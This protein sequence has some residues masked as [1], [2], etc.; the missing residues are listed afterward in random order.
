[1]NRLCI[2]CKKQITGYASWVKRAKFCS[3][4]CRYGWMK[5]NFN[6]SKKSIKRMSD[7]KKWFYTTHSA[8]NKNKKMPKSFGEKLRKL[9]SGRIVSD[10]TKKRMKRNHA[11]YRMNKHP[12][13][14]GGFYFRDGYVYVISKEHPFANG[15]GYVKKSRL[16]MEKHLTRFLKPEEVVH[17][18]NGIRNDDRIENL[19]LF[20][21]NSEH[22]KHHVGLSFPRT[23]YSS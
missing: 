11:D 12:R 10:I 21:N 19:K 1:M 9:F 14:K 22:R 16:T 4:E 23:I 2:S 13:W 17:H 18:I 7:G 5:E 6:H 8:W 15:I 20:K 3:N